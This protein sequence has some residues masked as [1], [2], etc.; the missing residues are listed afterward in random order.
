[1]QI[2]PAA[3]LPSQPSQEVEALPVQE[4][5]R[6]GKN[7]FGD[8]LAR[9]E[10]V[11]ENNSVAKIRSTIKEVT[12]NHGLQKGATLRNKLLASSGKDA[13]IPE[14]RDATLTPQDISALK[15]KLQ[16]VGVGK[17]VLK[18]LEEKVK[19]GSMTWNDMLQAIAKDPAF[20]GLAGSAIKLDNAT[21]NS[22]MLFFQKIGFTPDESTKL[23]GSLEK[24]DTANAWEKISQQLANLPPNT[25]ITLTSSDVAA[26]SKAMQ[27]PKDTAARLQAQ[28]ASLQQRLGKESPELT[29]K[30][31]KTFLHELSQSVMEKAKQ[32]SNRLGDLAKVISPAM[33]QAWERSSHLKAAD[34]RASSE[35][36]ASELLIKDGMTAKA[37]GFTHAADSSENREVNREAR[38]NLQGRESNTNGVT[39]AKQ[40]ATTTPT[41]KKFSPDQEQRGN[42]NQQDTSGNN[43]NANAWDTLLSKVTTTTPQPM[44]SGNAP[45]QGQQ[46]TF[47]QQNPLS[48]RVYEQIETGMLRTLKNGGKQLTLSLNPEELGK[49][50]VI[51][52]VKGN[53]LTATIRPETHEAAKAI[54]DQ[55]HTLKST[56]ENQGL[57]VERL[58]VQTQLQN[59]SGG[60]NWQGTSQHNLTQEQQEK[61]LHQRRLHNMRSKED[62]LA[63][64]MRK[65]VQTERTTLHTGLSIIA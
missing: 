29:P 33:E 18:E 63:R 13:S 37:N 11:A 10:S 2:F 23:L 6:T 3:I 8:M 22:A 48:T 49:V 39:S 12:E 17:E 21:R 32:A 36:A 26:L 5:S 20:S 19:Q 31:M 7:T 65:E 61:F 50:K 54:S 57:K 1:M 60:Q 47:L 27:L 46:S 28:F 41:G 42:E 15:K 58:D 51:L 4:T 14:L 38:T 16:K 62:D 53:E 25:Q 52:A 56:L 24:G 9:V 40:P 59:D 43:K 34:A 30:E 64:D 44:T 45:Q 35:T 55:L